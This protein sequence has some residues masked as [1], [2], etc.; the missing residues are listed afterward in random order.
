MSV[1][2]WSPVIWITLYVGKHFIQFMKSLLNLIK[3]L[4]C[5]DDIDC[6]LSIHKN[7]QSGVMGA[8]R[9]HSLKVGGSSLVG[10]GT[11]MDIKCYGGWWL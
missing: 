10:G 2:V 7:W 3:I 6:I 9:S 11:S 1:L 8:C 5:I 4:L